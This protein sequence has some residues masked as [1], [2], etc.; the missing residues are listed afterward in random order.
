MSEKTKRI[1]AIIA[2]VFMGV[3]TVSF[4]VFLVTRGNVVA[5][6]ALFSGV[7]GLCLFLVIRMFSKKQ[8][9]AADFNGD[10]D[11][12]EPEEGEPVDRG[13]EEETPVSDEKV[14]D[15]KQAE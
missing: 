11:A 6:V 15:E 9:E 2:L 3:F 10:S 5:F 13:E 8:E 1:L 14:D 4:I 12:D 7:V